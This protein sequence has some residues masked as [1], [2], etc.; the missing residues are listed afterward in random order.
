MVGRKCL[1]PHPYCN[2][3]NGYDDSCIEVLKPGCSPV[4]PIR[5]FFPL[6]ELLST[7]D[8]QHNILGDSDVSYI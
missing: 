8:D 3:E 4:L 2:H 5:A 6:Y 7:I 1:L